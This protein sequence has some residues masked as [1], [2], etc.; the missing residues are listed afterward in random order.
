M[1]A[2]TV[3]AGRACRMVP[4]PSRNLSNAGSS[5]AVVT[6]PGGMV[7]TKARRKPRVLNRVPDEL[8]LRWAERKI[9]S[10]LSK[11]PPRLT[12]T[13]PEVGPVGSVI[14]PVG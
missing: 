6:E 10:V 3:P 14:D 1:T 13:E 11:E 12:L 2:I 8:W 9:L 5:L 7:F 4:L